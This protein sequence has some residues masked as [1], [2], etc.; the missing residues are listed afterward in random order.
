M[1]ILVESKWLL[2]TKTFDRLYAPIAK[3]VSDSCKLRLPR[4]IPSKVSGYSPTLMSRARTAAL[5]HVNTLPFPTP[6]LRWFSAALSILPKTTER[7]SSVVREYR[8][9]AFNQYTKSLAKKQVGTTS[10]GAT[11]YGRI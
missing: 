8:H 3:Y 9:V 7:I 2:A 5:K 10:N 1:H 4:R 6:V 11:R